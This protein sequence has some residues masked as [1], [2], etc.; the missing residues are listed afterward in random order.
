M[1]HA[2]LA[3]VVCVS[4][5]GVVLFACDPASAAI[6]P[7]CPFHWLTGLYC[8]VCGSIR[9]MHALLHGHVLDAVRCNVLT[10]GTVVYAAAIA[11]RRRRAAPYPPL[12]R[13]PHARAVLYLAI[14]VGFTVVRNLPGGVGAL[15][16]P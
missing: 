11:I 1:I 10:L 16:R 2:R 9:G 7:I 3:A 14:V 8:P 4:V 13:L 6:Y 12:A 15:L 5:A